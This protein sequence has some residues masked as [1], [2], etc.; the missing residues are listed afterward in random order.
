MIVRLAWKSAGRVFV[1][2]PCG[3]NRP[4]KKHTVRIAKIIDVSDHIVTTRIQVFR[5]VD[6]ETI[7][8]GATCKKLFLDDILTNKNI[9]RC[10]EHTIG[11]I[12]S[13]ILGKIHGDRILTQSRG[14][15]SLIAA[16]DVDIQLIALE[17]IRAA[18][19]NQTAFS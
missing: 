18:I 14:G 15:C 3:I 7:D 4:R 16:I 5:Q 11:S 13:A 8:R 17:D 19:Y 6:R 10:S 1:D 12:Q 9:V 2:L